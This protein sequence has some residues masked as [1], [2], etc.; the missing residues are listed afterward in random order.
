MQ[1]IISLPTLKSTAKIVLKIGVCGLVTML[2]RIDDFGY[3]LIVINGGE[4]H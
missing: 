3:K 1:N 4:Y 2:V